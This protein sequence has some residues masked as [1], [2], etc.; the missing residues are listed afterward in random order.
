MHRFVCYFWAPTAWGKLYYIITT[1]TLS[2]PG[3][4]N[5]WSLNGNHFV[6][7]NKTVWCRDFGSGDRYINVSPPLC[8]F[9]FDPLDENIFLET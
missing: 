3:L 9:L 7:N 4:L 6:L 8:S 2:F 5:K 1:Y